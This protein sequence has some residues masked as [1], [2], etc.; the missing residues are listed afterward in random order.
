MGP[1]CIFK[2]WRLRGLNKFYTGAQKPMQRRINGHPHRF[3]ELRVCFFACPPKFRVLNSEAFLRPF[4]ADDHQSGGRFS[5]AQRPADERNA[6][7]SIQAPED[8]KARQA[9]PGPANSSIV[10]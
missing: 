6:Y 9:R 4:R 10:L 1:S 7:E 3:K 2:N 8:A 5:P